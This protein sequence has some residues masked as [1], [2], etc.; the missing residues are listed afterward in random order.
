MFVFT[1]LVVWLFPTFRDSFGQTLKNVPDSLKSVLGQAADYQRLDGFLQL[2]V[3]M[4]MIFVTFI[5]G[6]VLFTGLLAGDESSGTLQTLL[7]QPVSR[8]KVY[9]QKLI[10]GAILLGIVSLV[11]FVGV[12]AGVLLIHDHVN[13]LRLLEAT[14][15]QWLVSLVLS[16]LGYSIGAM[17]GKRGVAGAMA[18]L[19]AFVAYMVFTVSGTAKF[20]KIP[21]YFSPFKYLASPRILDAGI[22]WPNVIGLSLICLG[23]AVLGWGVFT[24]RDIYPK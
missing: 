11:M 3:F 15:M 16:L 7:A 8:T 2:Q 9:F 1:L 23:L 17:S 5:Y 21:N 14:G 19:Y 22:S 20:L 13:W 10:A 18:G 4:Q 24:K 6:I 12:A